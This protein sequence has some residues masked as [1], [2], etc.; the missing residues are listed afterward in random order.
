LNTSIYTGSDQKTLR[1][2]VNLSKTR[3]TKLLT[4]NIFTIR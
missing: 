1:P 3:L 4:N 2:V